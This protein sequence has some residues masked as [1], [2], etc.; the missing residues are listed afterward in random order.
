VTKIKWVTSTVAMAL[1]ARLLFIPGE[2]LERDAE[3]QAAYEDYRSCVRID[4]FCLPAH[5]CPVPNCM[6]EFLR[7]SEDINRHHT[8]LSLLKPRNLLS[9][10][11]P[12]R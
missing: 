10:W 6:G 4:I 8:L 1:I 11:Q 9:G 5:P 7:R 12:F 2:K 3:V